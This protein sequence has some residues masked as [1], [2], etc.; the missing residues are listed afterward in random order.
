MGAWGLHLKKDAWPTAPT[1]N[2]GERIADWWTGWLCQHH[3]DNFGTRNIP[4]GGFISW[5]QSPFHTAG[6][7]CQ[8]SRQRELINRFD[9]RYLIFIHGLFFSS[10]LSNIFTIQD[11][12]HQLPS[13]IPN[14]CPLRRCTASLILY[15]PVHSSPNRR[16]AA[17]Q[18][19]CSDRIS[20]P[21]NT[22]PYLS[23]GQPTWCRQSLFAPSSI[24]ELPPSKKST[25]P[26]RAEIPHSP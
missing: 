24:L 12:R 25:D 17:W 4:I 16:L 11:S 21:S 15:R 19:T 3:P 23:L 6:K 14:H 1:G 9:E 5:V 22:M 10:S 18:E 13:R 2:C 7:L 8:G 26:M 20:A